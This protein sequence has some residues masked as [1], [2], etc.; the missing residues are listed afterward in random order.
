MTATKI[1]AQSACA[2]LGSD[3]ARYL[4]RNPDACISY[5]Q[6]CREAGCLREARAA[7]WIAH[8]AD[9]NCDSLGAQ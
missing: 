9:S 1:D 5:A 4:W 6:G 2:T 7:E 8:C 3:F